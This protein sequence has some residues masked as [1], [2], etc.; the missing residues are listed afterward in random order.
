MSFDT[1]QKY[2]NS[3]SRRY[4]KYFWID[5]YD[6]YAKNRFV[7]LL[8]K[9]EYSNLAISIKF[10]NEKIGNNTMSAINNLHKTMVKN[11]INVCKKNMYCEDNYVFM[12]CENDKVH[13][14]NSLLKNN[15][16]SLINNLTEISNEIPQNNPIYHKMQNLMKKK[17]N[18]PEFEKEYENMAPNDKDNIM[19]IL[20]EKVEN[21]KEFYAAFVPLE[22]LREL[23]GE[24]ISNL[25]KFDSTRIKKGPMSS[26]TINIFIPIKRTVN[27]GES[28]ENSNIFAYKKCRYITRIL[29]MRE[30]AIG[31]SKCNSNNGTSSNYAKLLYQIYSMPFTINIFESTKT[32]IINWHEKINI[33]ERKNKIFSND[34]LIILSKPVGPKEINSGFYSRGNYNKISLFRKEEINKILLHELMHYTQIDYGLH[35]NK[36]FAN[37]AK[38]KLNY[39][40]FC[41]N[42]QLGCD[43]A[44]ILNDSII[45]NVNEGYTDFCADIINTL[46]FSCEICFKNGMKSKSIVKMWVAFLSTECN[47]A[48]F[49]VAKILIYFNFNYYEQIFKNNSNS[50]S[51]LQTTNLFS[52]FVVRAAL[53]YNIAEI[54]EILNQYYQCPNFVYYF[55]TFDKK[56][57]QEIVDKIINILQSDEFAQIINYNI[58]LIKNLKI[59]YDTRISAE[60]KTNYE[61]N[62]F[63]NEIYEAMDGLMTTM[64]RSVIEIE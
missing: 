24:K 32:K 58:Q 57:R 34:D 25:C 63:S 52:Y 33:L 41:D 8:S 14:N 40:K 53:L 64:R 61:A 37:F 35:M 1:T 28:G 7:N 17:N 39:R 20:S 19:K 12:T 47:F 44:A 15:K 21:Y 43:D 27:F 54:F 42:S 59:N 62:N 48:L 18:F 13:N 45:M 29:T 5:P 4:S 38:K 30:L 51:I 36:T 9:N 46:L 26:Y 31:D 2:L 49:Q 60:L 22:I 23:E 6:G 10:Y 11:L 16:F 55:S 56:K 50:P 3:F